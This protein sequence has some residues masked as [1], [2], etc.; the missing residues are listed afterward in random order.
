MELKY[1]ETIQH[2]KALCN[3]RRGRERVEAALKHLVSTPVSGVSERNAAIF[4]HRHTLYGG[5]YPTLKFIGDMYGVQQERVR[6]IE[7]ITARKVC[8]RLHFE[9]TFLQREAIHA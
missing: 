9:D 5:R 2:T 4:L 6:Q 7:S 1:P 3:T 8:Q